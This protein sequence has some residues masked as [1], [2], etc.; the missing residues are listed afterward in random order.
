MSAQV[1]VQ[2]NGRQPRVVTFTTTNL[3]WLDAIREEY[4]RRFEHDL[5]IEQVLDY[6]IISEIWSL[7]REMYLS[8]EQT[9]RI[10]IQGDL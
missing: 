6:A 9:F 2:S 5:T 4:N 1:V 8:E 10:G 7:S 3:E